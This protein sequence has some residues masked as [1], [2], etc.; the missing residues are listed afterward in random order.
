MRFLGGE[1]RRDGAQGQAAE[2]SSVDQ[3]MH[4]LLGHPAIDRLLTHL[5]HRPRVFQ[6]VAFGLTQVLVVFFLLHGTAQPTHAPRTTPAPVSGLQRVPYTNA[7]ALQPGQTDDAR[8]LDVLGGY[9][10]ASIIAD[11]QNQLSMLL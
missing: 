3:A 4:Y 2:A 5:L 1:P 6:L 10:Q 11:Q 9:I 8:L 7:P